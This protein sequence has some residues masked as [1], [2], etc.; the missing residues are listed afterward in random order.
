M[1]YVI[2]LALLLCLPVRGEAWQ[3]MGGGATTAQCSATTDYIGNESFIEMS[4]TTGD[5]TSDRMMVSLHTPNCSS[6]CSNGALETVYLYH[7]ST[8]TDN[9]KVCIYADDGDSTPDSGDILVGCSDAMTSSAQEDV[10]ASIAG[11]ISCSSP[12]WMVLVASANTWMSR[13]TATGTTYHQVVS[14]AYASPPNTLSGTWTTASITTDAHV[15]IG[16]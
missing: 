3:V 8:A 2:L 10:T 13:R 7:S 12:Y 1:R 5:L 6:G 9:A 14:G 11:D 15:T 16:P 4:G